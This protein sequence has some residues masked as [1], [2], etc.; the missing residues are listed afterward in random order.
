MYKPFP[1]TVDTMKKVENQMFTI[2]TNDL[3]TPKLIIT[4][5]QEGQ[6]VILS[7]GVKVRIAIKKPNSQIVF[8]DCEI[9]DASEGTCEVNLTTQAYVIEGNH[10]AEILVYY[11]PDSVS[12]TARFSYTTI[13]GLFDE[14]TTESSNDFQTLNK[15]V[16]DAETA[17]MKA[18]EHEKNA[19]Q[20]AKNAAI[21][22]ANNNQTVVETVEARANFPTLKDRLSDF[23]KKVSG[24]G[25]VYFPMYTPQM[26]GATGKVEQDATAIIQSILDIAITRGA[27]YCHIPKGTYRLTNRL[28]LSTNT[29]I[30]MDKG[31]TLIRDHPAGWFVNGKPGDSFTGYNG[32]GN[33]TIE[34]GV[35]DGNLVNHNNYFNAIGLARGQNIVLRNIEIRD[36]RG[37]HAVDLNACKDVLIEKCRFKGYDI[38][39]TVN[40]DG[41]SKERE[42]IQ[43]SAHTEGGFNFFGT[44]D[45]LPCENVTVR[46]NYFGKS[47][48]LPAYPAGVGN[49]G[50]T[51]DK[52][53]K[54]IRVYDNTFDGMTFAGVRPFVFHNT[55]IKG[56]TFID[57]ENGVRFS[58]SDGGTGTPQAG[59]NVTIESNLF[60]NSKKRDIYLVGQEK[61]GVAAKVKN[62]QILN[63][64]SESYEGTV[65]ENVY[66]SFCDNVLI[67]GNTSRAA[68]R[69][70]MATY[71][72]NVKIK[73]NNTYDLTTEIA[74]VNDDGTYV[75]LGYTKDFYISGN[76]GEKNGRSGFLLT[77]VDGIDAN[78]NILI[79]PTIETTNTRSGFSL[80]GGSKNGRIYNNKVQGANQ[81]YG[82]DITSTCSDIQT[83]NNDLVGLTKPMSNASI[84][85]FEGTYMHSANG[86]RYKLTVT[87][88]G[89]PLFTAG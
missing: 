9:V 45:G 28:F 2:N 16:Y 89:A 33:I 78:S 18:S 51:F 44:W 50:H 8:L 41:G 59:K 74:Y 12:V 24:A 30:V 10:T 35:L 64:I 53:N 13:K 55:W 67:Q 40:G 21:S 75:G 85:G 66:L 68:Y 80:T 15:I 72:N 76:R 32:N 25:D 73:D 88:A 4:I 52:Y 6:P 29:K 71:C 14:G 37:A 36:V 58:N 5:L 86:T 26:R 82:I 83:F 31:V 46:D 63:N 39:Y 84:G 34:G 54:N 19:F 77:G 7:D 62:I 27:V 56:N 48:N 47:D 57:C 11:A 61:G 3:N 42:A 65:N 23:D 70:V 38:N 22:E 60:I 43:I 1:I 69:F 49:H 87:D 81:K 79:D 17:Q 20:S